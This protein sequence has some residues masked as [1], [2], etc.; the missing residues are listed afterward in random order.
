MKST[1]L[2]ECPFCHGEGE[3]IERDERGRTIIR[4]CDACGAKTA[5]RRATLFRLANI[6][7]TV[8]DAAP[9][10]EVARYIAEF[11]DAR[12][13]RFWLLLTGKPGCGKTTNAAIIARELIERYGARVRFYNAGEL[14]RKLLATRKRD[15]DYSRAV[16]EYLDADLVIV[17]DFLKSIPRASSYSF[18]EFR[19]TTLDYMW[20]RY[21][22]GKPL[23]LTT[24]RR[25]D[26]IG[27]FDAALA[28]RIAETCKGRAVVFGMTAANWRIKGEGNGEDTFEAASGPT[29]GGARSASGARGRGLGDESRVANV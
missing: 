13:G 29:A 22:A 26:E 10:E 16:D 21:D 12:G 7:Q 11:G 28:G 4:D 24:Q 5:K 17:D 9:S 2:F 8:A 27:Q 14:T 19:E 6:P 20:R 25:F 23:V 18:D 3:I 15:K 1:D